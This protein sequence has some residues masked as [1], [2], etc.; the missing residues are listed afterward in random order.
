MT[1][2]PILDFIWFAWNA[3]YSGFRGVVEVLSIPM[4]ELGP[5]SLAGTIFGDYTLFEV[6]FSLGL[7]IFIGYVIVSFIIDILP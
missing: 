7:P 6:M 4:K 5:L 1:E 3:M 2:T